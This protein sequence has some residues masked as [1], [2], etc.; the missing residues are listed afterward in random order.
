MS[1]VVDPSSGTHG[2]HVV[3]PAGRFTPPLSAPITQVEICAAPPAP[4]VSPAPAPAMPLALAVEALSR[5]TAIANGIK[6]PDNDSPHRALQVALAGLRA[7]RRPHETSGI[8]SL[9]Y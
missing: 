6:R 7:N 5:A 8:R 1:S 9:D 4:G 3:V 2:V